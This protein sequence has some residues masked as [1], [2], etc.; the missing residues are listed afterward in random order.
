[1]GR[2]KK[3]IFR[4]NAGTTMVEVLVAFSVLI[5]IMGIF[6]QAMTLAGRMMG[7]SE[8]TLE[9]YRELAGGYYLER[10]SVVDISESE[11]KDMTFTRNP[12]HEGFAIRARL[13]TYTMKDGT[14]KL[15]EVVRETAAGDGA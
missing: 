1:M 14:G 9:N 12:G 10:G 3:M 2:L 13:K 5:L 15:V 4:S 7:R 11:E 6:S 8:D